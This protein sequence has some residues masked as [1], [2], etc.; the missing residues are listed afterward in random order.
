MPG[1]AYRPKC[2]IFGYE[3]EQNLRSIIY[4][5]FNHEFRLLGM[6][7]MPRLAHTK[8]AC[9]RTK[10]GSQIAELPP[11][12]LILFIAVF[13]PL[14]NL[15]YIFIAYCA[16]WYLNASEMR[17]VAC[18][19]PIGLTTTTSNG[20]TTYS[21]ATYTPTTFP[22]S[23]SLPQS[24]DWH[25]FM[26]VVESSD[27][28]SITYI[29]V[30]SSTNQAGQAEVTTTVTVQPFLRQATSWLPKIPGVNEE[31]TFVYKNR[32]YQEEETP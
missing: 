14:L 22:S 10:T 24:T 23:F 19:A 21:N 1:P 29:P 8:R 20:S 12:L 2:P 3:N 9:S 17:Q 31:I 15:L 32:I 11:A 6:T 13:F 16:G 4:Y 26:G 5:A 18:Q 28:P 27:S 30:N 25:G 7:S